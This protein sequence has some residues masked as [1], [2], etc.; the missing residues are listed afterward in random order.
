[1]FFNKAS[2][3]SFITYCLNILFYA[4]LS[5]PEGTHPEDLNSVAVSTHSSALILSLYFMHSS[6]AP[7]YR[8]HDKRNLCFTRRRICSI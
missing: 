7:Q 8:T 1:M 2:F 6:V 4:N 3:F 5:V